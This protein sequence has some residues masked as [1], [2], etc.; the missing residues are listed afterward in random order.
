[1]AHRFIIHIQLLIPAAAKCNCDCLLFL[2]GP[3]SR[4]LQ[5]FDLAHRNGNGETADRWSCKSLQSFLF[6]Y[7]LFLVTFQ[8]M[9]HGCSHRKLPRSGW[10][11]W[12]QSDGR[13]NWAKVKLRMGSR[14]RSQ[15]PKAPITVFPP[16]TPNR[17]AV[18]QRIRLCHIGV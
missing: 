11:L 8:H 2:H 16:L 15:S 6:S 9:Q 5:I 12:Q 13:R 18:A 14:T 17:I 4:R 10:H 1:M 3:R 7:I